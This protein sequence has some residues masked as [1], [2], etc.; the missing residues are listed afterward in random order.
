VTPGAIPADL[1]LRTEP[2]PSDEQAVAAIVRSTGFFSEAETAIAA[3]LVRE[4]CTRGE[5][6]GYRF[7]FLDRPGGDVV[8]YA[9]YGEIPCT[10]GSFD[11][12][13]IAVHERERG[14][15]LGRFL[16]AETERRIRDLG[17]RRV[18]A[19]TSGRP[20]Y[21]PTRS[22]YESNGYRVGAELEHFYGVG[23]AKVVYVKVV[24]REA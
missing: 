5:E 14:R 13:W 15:G 7:V 4:A 17:G 20:Q 18:Y 6:S 2:R 9:C 10:V 21:E 8:G 11:L 23:D 24:G 1:Q 3:E 19:E 22:F 16:L 12:Y